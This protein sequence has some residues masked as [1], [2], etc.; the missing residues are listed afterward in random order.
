MPLEIISQCDC[1]FKNENDV[2]VIWSLFKKSYFVDCFADILAEKTGKPTDEIKSLAV[3]YEAAGIH[4][5]SINDVKKEIEDDLEWAKECKGCPANF[6]K[7]NFGCYHNI[8]YPIS[9][10]FEELLVQQVPFLK[11][12]ALDLLLIALKDFSEV[13]AITEEF[14][15]AGY[16]ESDTASVVT[17]SLNGIL[18]EISSSF[19]LGLFLFSGEEVSPNHLIVT[20]LFW[21]LF[22]P[23]K[24]Y[25]DL[26]NQKLIESSLKLSEKSNVY[27]QTKESDLILVLLQSIK[28]WIPLFLSV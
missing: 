24:S 16:L 22:Q 15:S 6:R 27:S 21:G 13:M 8:S 20:L 7:Q 5:Q 1:D 3:T 28:Q 4:S 12:W 19:L 14:R 10:K 23:L 25:E 18:T 17:I 26:K 2:E 11:P 9:A